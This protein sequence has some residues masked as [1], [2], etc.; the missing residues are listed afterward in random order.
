MAEPYD[1]A[2][3]AASKLAVIN[4]SLAS[5]YAAWS[6]LAAAGK[7]LSLTAEN[8]NSLADYFCRVTAATAEL[9]TVLGMPVVP[10]PA[11]DHP[12]P[13]AE[14][15]KGRHLRVVGGRKEPQA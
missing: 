2:A 10:L 13:P 4:A 11:T 5:A 15:P 14:R 8:L 6:D 3:L 9:A 12:A 7:P 1:R